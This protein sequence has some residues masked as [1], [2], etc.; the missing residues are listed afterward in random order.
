MRFRELE[1]TSVAGVSLFVAKKTHSAT[2]LGD[3][4]GLID[5]SG[6]HVFIR[7]YH[8]EGDKYCIVAESDSFLWSSFKMNSLVILNYLDEGYIKD[9]VKSLLEEHGA[10]V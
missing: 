6:G 1:K 2:C 3:V 8:T 10:E 4:A 5:N 9:G 7:V